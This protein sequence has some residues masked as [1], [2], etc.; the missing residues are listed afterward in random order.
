MIVIM[1]EHREKEQQN[2]SHNSFGSSLSRIRSEKLNDMGYGLSRISPI[3]F[4]GDVFQTPTNRTQDKAPTLTPRKRR[5]E[6]NTESFL[7]RQVPQQG[8]NTKSY[9]AELSI[10]GKGPGEP[11]GR[12]IP[13]KLNSTDNSSQDT[14]NLSTT[15][16][17]YDKST[18]ECQNKTTSM[19]TLPRD[20]Q[21]TGTTTTTQMS[22]EMTSQAGGTQTT[23]PP[24]PKKST[25]TGGMQTSPPTGNSCQQ[26]GQVNWITIKIKKVN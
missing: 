23:P 18:G 19:Q 17:Y 26:V 9:N 22:N 16:V 12:F 20:S 25:S 8:E 5:S 24:S 11:S 1:E 14:D 3:T 21:P 2:I 15:T 10:A 7:S 13:P 6:I 4:D